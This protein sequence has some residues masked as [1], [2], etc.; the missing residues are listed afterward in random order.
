MAKHGLE[1][2][3]A[4][5]ALAGVLVVEGV[6][7]ALFGIAALFWPS[8]TAVVF[9]KL[10]GVF[11][12][13][14]G[15]VSLVH[16]LLGIGRSGLWWVESIFSVAA[17][18]LGVFLLRNPDISAAVMILMV[19]FTLIGRGVVDVLTGLFVKDADV[20]QNRWFYIIM[21]VV[22]FAAGIAVLA[23]PVASGLV[24]IWALGF[25]MLMSG[26]LNIGLAF[27]VRNSE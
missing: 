23:H 16:S 17:L 2:S 15:L 5:D 18:G 11:V 22:G 4:R 9:I 1:E 3:K 7:T 13:V 8:L 21:G 14:W 10:F 12:L 20:T 19:G 6:I 25:Y 26:A 27:R 24:F